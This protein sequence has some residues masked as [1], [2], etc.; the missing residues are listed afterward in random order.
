MENKSH[1]LMTGLFTLFLL[2]AAILGAIWFNRDRV[3]T[4]SYQIATKLSIPGLNPE[5]SVRYRGL[6]VGKVKTIDFD[7]QVTGQ[8]LINITVTPDT[9][10]T[11]STYAMLGYLKASQVLH[12]CSL[13]TMGPISID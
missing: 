5:A 10:I 4:V 12:L 13:M 7:P 11:Y 2:T 1:A 9:P 6:E 3:E 8:I